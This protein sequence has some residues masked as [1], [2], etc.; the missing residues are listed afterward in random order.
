[1]KYMWKE[2]IAPYLYENKI[3]YMIFI[4]FI[5]ITYLLSS[6][7]IPMNISYLINSPNGKFTTD[8]FKNM[9]TNTK[10]GY[11]YIFNNFCPSFNLHYFI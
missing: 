3:M 5:I 4:I 8:F 6:L 10:T 2:F 9:K 11:L 1:M 7:I